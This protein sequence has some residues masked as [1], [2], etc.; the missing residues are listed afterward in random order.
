VPARTSTVKTH[1][2][3][4]QAFH[5]TLK[6]KNQRANFHLSHLKLFGGTINLTLQEK[7]GH[8]TAKLQAEK[9]NLQKIHTFLRLKSLESLSGKATLSAQLSGSKLSHLDKAILS[10][11]VTELSAQDISGNLASE[12]L[13]LHSE[14]KLER[15]GKNWQWQTQQRLSKGAFYID[16]I[17]LDIEKAQPISLKASGSLDSN[18]KAITLT[19]VSLKHKGIAHIDAKALIH[20]K[21]TEPILK[22]ADINFYADNLETISSLYLAPFLEGKPI[23]DLSLQGNLSATLTIENQALHEAHLNFNSLQLSSKQQAISIEQL[24]G[25][26]YWNHLWENK[27]DSHLYWQALSI[28]N[29]PFTASQLDF[30]LAEQQLNLL[31][32][33]K[34]ALLDGILSIEKFDFNLNAAVES[35]VTLRAR[36]DKLSLNELSAA[37]HWE[38]PLSGTLSGYIPS[39]NYH[40]KKLTLEGGLKM[41]LF[42]GE[43][44]ISQLAASGLL[45]DFSQFYIDLEFENLDLNEVTKKF[46]I[47]RIQGR[48][49][50]FA[51]NVYLEN[52]QPIS[53]YAWLGTP[54]D[55]DSRHKI[56]HRAVRNIASLGGSSAADVISRGVLSWFDDFGYDRLGIGCYLHQGVCQ[57][58]GAAAASQGY[59]LIKGGGIP[60][61]DIIGFN[62]RVNWH[63]LMNR[64]SRITANNM[65]VEP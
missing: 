26:V 41:Q 57:M 45:T 61:I 2:F 20:Y 30:S 65:V 47:G 11:I 16:P 18:N 58:T 38:N 4:Q 64:L 60:S 1:L 25:S 46:P 63:T 43:I 33:A 49:S 37:M 17:Y 51:H 3:G 40:Q 32:P 10:A 15:Q 21:K 28:K 48:L 14:L 8:W 42:D 27:Q 34:L 24:A 12:A 29:I 9:I 6:V 39:V 44:R 52:W 5:F 23:Q 56:S 59:Y 36:L 22:Q 55:D 31:Q 54:D 35:S 7:K 13:T 53:F 62:T 50:G 19:S